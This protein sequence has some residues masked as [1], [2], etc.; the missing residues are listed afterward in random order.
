MPL[1]ML[2]NT[3]TGA[4]SFKFMTGKFRIYIEKTSSR[5]VS[6]VCL[7]EQNVMHLIFFEI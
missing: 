6:S 1:R 4:G 3:E 2:T 7:S 5:N